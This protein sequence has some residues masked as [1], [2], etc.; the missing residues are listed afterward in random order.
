MRRTNCNLHDHWT[1]VRLA[2]ETCASLPSS[3]SRTERRREHLRA[4]IKMYDGHS[5]FEEEKEVKCRYCFR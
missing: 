2:L 3:G 4:C 1:S 5:L